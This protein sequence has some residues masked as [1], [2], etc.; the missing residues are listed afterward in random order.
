MTGEAA[1][2]TM[3]DPVPA[4]TASHRWRDRARRLAIPADQPVWA[5]P[6]VFMLAGV[7][8][9]LYAWRSSGY[10]EVYY[11]AAVRSMSM[12]WHNFLFSAFD[13]A[14]TVTT[15]KL[16]GAF[17]VQALSVRLFGLHDWAIVLPQIVEGALT[18]LVLYRAVR[19][20]AGPVAG[21][22]ASLVL[23]VSPANVALNRGNVSDTL[24]V[25]LVVL[26]AD[27]I[28]GA[29]LTGRWRNLLLGALWIGL[30]F[31]TKMLEAW[32][33][34]PALGL[35]Y[36]VAGAPRLLRRVLGVALLGALAV[37]A[38]AQLD[39]LRDARSRRPAGPSSTGATTTRCSSRCSTT[40]GSDGSISP[41]R[42]PCSSARSASVD[43]HRRRRA[44]T[45]C[46]TGP[47]GPTPDGCC[48]PR[49]RCWSVAC[50][51]GAGRRGATHCGPA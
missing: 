24:M 11:A 39:V 34:L 15:D 1:A 14:G 4:A 6:L 16:P 37:L 41:P 25:L 5:R 13:P 22:V 51:R 23:V 36:L 7:A 3:A 47:S 29:V 46:C 49:R 21:L 27:A 40:T 19:R 31:Q 33:I 10:L 8:A 28:V 26:A 43:C 38:V 44:G 18:V 2:A 50:S 32:L 9:F 20:L 17:W 45:G 42:T 48:R 30:A 12:S 35:A